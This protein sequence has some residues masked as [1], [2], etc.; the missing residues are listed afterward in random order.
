MKYFIWFNFRP[1]I[2]VLTENAKHLEHV[3]SDTN[4]L[5]E[6]VSSKVRILDLAKVELILC[7]FLYSMCN[8]FYFYFNFLF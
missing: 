5:A 6:K 7:W 4:Q 2:E 1:N 3:I 8:C